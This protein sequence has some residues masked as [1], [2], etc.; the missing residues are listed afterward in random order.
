MEQAIVVIWGFMGPLILIGI[1]GIIYGIY[2]NKR[3]KEG[4]CHCP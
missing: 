1:I 2:D 4:Q 3:C